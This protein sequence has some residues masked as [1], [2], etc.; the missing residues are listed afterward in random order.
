[1]QI[2]KLMGIDVFPIDAPG[3]GKTLVGD[4]SEVAGDFPDD[5]GFLV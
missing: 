3:L 1:M 4:Y 5:V 2:A